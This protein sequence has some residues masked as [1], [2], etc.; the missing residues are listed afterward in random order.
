[1]ATFQMPGSGASGELGE[2]LK[3]AAVVSVLA[4]ARMDWAAEKAADQM[5]ERGERA[6]GRM[7]TMDIGFAS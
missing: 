1:M 4:V 6:L 5:I 2:H 7:A 3:L